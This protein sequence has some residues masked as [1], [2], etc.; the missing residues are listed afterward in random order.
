MDPCLKKN[1]GICLHVIKF[2]LPVKRVR[3]DCA[4]ID[5]TLSVTP[6]GCYFSSPWQTVR[7]KKNASSHK[8][9]MLL[10][11]LLVSAILLLPY[12]FTH[13]ESFPLTIS[14]VFFFSTTYL[15]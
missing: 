5:M 6:K 11:P 12:C 4:E 13:T 1:D 7:Q 15:L 2:D 10:L 3:D 8:N 9:Q 14:R